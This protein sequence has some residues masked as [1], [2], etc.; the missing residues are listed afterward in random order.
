[1]SQAGGQ[2]RAGAPAGRHGGE[3]RAQA[4]ASRPGERHRPVYA[5]LP[6]GCVPVATFTPCPRQEVP[7]RT[8]VVR[9]LLLPVLAALSSSC[10][11]SPKPAAPPVDMTAILVSVDSLNKVFLAAVAARDTNTIVGMYADDA[12]VLPP[13]RTRVDGRD[14][15][16]V[17]WAGFLGTPGLQ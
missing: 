1:A 16:R 12:H 17:M 3:R 7:M 9:L 4:V 15:I 14:S 5:G 11:G 2:R 6:R 8:P 10:A 13:G